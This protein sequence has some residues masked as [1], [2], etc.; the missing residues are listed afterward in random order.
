MANLTER[1]RDADH[2][3]AAADA[4]A[5][6]LD[7]GL[8]T[9]S[10]HDL[11]ADLADLDRLHVRGERRLQAAGART[12]HCVHVGMGGEVV[13]ERGIAS[14]RPGKRSHSVSTAQAE[15]CRLRTNG[16]SGPWGVTERRPHWSIT[17]FVTSFVTS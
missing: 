15:T 14:I 17:S 12:E 11:L 5:C 13:Q 8:A 16:P 4:R 10:A 3:A 9:P 7:S 1:A 2:G 6:D